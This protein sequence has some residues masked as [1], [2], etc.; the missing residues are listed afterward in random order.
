MT[1][2]RKILVMVLVVGILTAISY[3]AL[4][5]NSGH[6][7]NS[8]MDRN[9][10]NNSSVNQSNVIPLERPPFLEDEKT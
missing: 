8:T 6:L 9:E 1:L 2:K 5:F 10:T 7:N 3:A 4:D